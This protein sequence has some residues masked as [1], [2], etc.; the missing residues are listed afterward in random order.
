MSNFEHQVAGHDQIVY[1]EAGKLAKPC[2]SIEVQF[3]EQ[4]QNTKLKAWMPKYFGTIPYQSPNESTQHKPH[5]FTRYVVLENLVEPYIKPCIADI[6]V[7]TRL[8][9]EDATSA[10]KERMEYQAQNTTSGSTGLRICGI[11]VYDETL[12]NFTSHDKSLGRSLTP[13]TI[14]DGL[15]V[16]LPT[17]VYSSVLDVLL[18]SLRA[19]RQDLS[20][21]TARI[22]ASSVLLLY[23]GSTDHQ[24]GPRVRLI[25]FAHAHFEPEGAGPDQGALFGLDNLCR[26][27]EKLIQERR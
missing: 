15:R 2:S 12:G 1:V 11:K 27:I 10:K 17:K 14:I 16:F 8:Y 25:D 13:D 3:Y 18:A 24:M 7:G 9:G 4:A 5:E 19:I 20:E 26:L 6:K 22:Y 23:E 21:S